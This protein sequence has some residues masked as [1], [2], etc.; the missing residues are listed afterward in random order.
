[1]KIYNLYPIPIW[2]DNLP[3]TPTDTTKAIEYCRELQQKDT[4]GVSL[5][6]IGGWQS[7]SFF[8]D[9]ITNTPLEIYFRHIKICVDKVFEDLDSLRECELINVWININKRN[10]HNIS[11]IHPASSISG[12]FYLTD[13][14]SDIVFQRPSDA[15]SAMM[16][17]VAS[18]CRTSLTNLETAF[19]PAVND[20][21]LFP[22]WMQH[23]VKP[24]LLDQERI[25]IAFNI[26][27][28]KYK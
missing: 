2:Y 20:L 18:Q 15:N 13:N 4:A 28:G 12:S 10:D 26:S 25:S 24:N 3:V 19:K 9:S 5:T 27:V 6:N 22:S 14:N 21:F 16:S 1:M 17:G 23:Y 7:G 8:H 11:H